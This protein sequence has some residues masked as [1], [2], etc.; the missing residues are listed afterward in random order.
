MI[1]RFSA[2]G[3]VHRACPVEKKCV[4]TGGRVGAADCCVEQEPLR[5][6]GRVKIA[7]RVPSERIITGGRVKI[8]GCEV[9]ER[10]VSLSCVLTRIASVRG[11]LT[12]CVNDESAKHAGAPN[13]RTIAVFC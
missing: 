9:E 3:R 12:A 10:V 13:N 4:S 1:E 5:A 2:I 6:G 11:G 7:G 8:A